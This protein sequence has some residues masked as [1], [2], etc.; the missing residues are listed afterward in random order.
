MK[1]A[2]LLELLRKYPLRRL[3]KFAEYVH[4]PYFNK[5]P[6]LGKLF[7]YL[8]LCAPDFSDAH[9]LNKDTIFRHLQPDKQPDVAALHRWFSELLQLFYD[10]LALQVWQQQPVRRHLL[11]LRELRK[12]KADH[13]YDL[14]LRDCQQDLQ[15]PRQLPQSER[16][17]A[18]YELHRE[19][20]AR[21]IDNGGRQYDPNLQAK[22]D[23]L[24][25]FFI[26]EKLKMACDM[27]N[28]N[29]VVKAN[30]QC[31]L[32]DALQTHIAQTAL[33]EQPYIQLYQ[34][35]LKM[36]Q[37]D[38]ENDYK[39]LKQLLLQYSQQF[40]I[41]EQTDMYGYALNFAIQQINKG[42]PEYYREAFDHY[43]LMVE[44]RLIFV[45][46]YLPAWDY[47]NI[48]TIA[49][50]LEEYGWTEQ[51]IRDYRPFLPADMRENAYRYNLASYYY[52][53]GK[54]GEAL[55]ALHNVEFTDA[56]Y[57]IG[58]KMIQ[59]KSYYQLREGEALRSL[60]NS[61]E[62]LLRRHKNLSDY[63]KESNLNCVKLAHRLYNLLEKKGI[64]SAKK[65]QEEQEKM[66][67]ALRET[68]PLANKPW[69]EQCL[70]EV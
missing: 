44:N 53:I 1:D 11:V 38:D 33:Q 47:K 23:A 7:D 36:R 43:R 2:K 3:N 17:Y 26:S 50:R 22:N 42:K 55:Q 57:Q 70:K 69:L 58:A 63:W 51:F 68:S 21:F 10:F 19:L 45:D 13:A 52:A 14:V 27:A 54:C 49:L 60:A 30:Y 64:L 40:T 9:R 20:D 59:L 32:L 4:S 61:F 65:W 46:D 8:L 28:R 6:M 25:A 37:T 15:D 18:Q 39:Q 41:A 12:Q 67:Q 62:A 29:I 5:R 16:Q 48:V 24:D 35:I 31:T 34:T 56:T 66:A